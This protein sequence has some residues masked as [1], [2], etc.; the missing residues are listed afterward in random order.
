MHIEIGNVYTTV[1]EL[2][3]TELDFLLRL[4]VVQVP[5]YQHTT[6]YKNGTW[7]GYKSFFAQT[8]RR[9]LSGFLPLVVTAAHEQGI[10][11]YAT[12]TRTFVPTGDPTNFA[13]RYPSARPYQVTALQHIFTS[14]LRFE[15]I[16]AP[17]ARGIVKIPTGGGK[18]FVGG[19]AIDF[20]HKKTLFVV[21][22]KNLAHQT[23][24]ELRKLTD[25]SVGILGDGRQ[26]YGD[27]TV[28]IIQ[29]VRH[30]LKDRAF[31]KYLASIDTLVV[32]ECHHVNKGTYHQL[33]TKCP[34]FFRFGLSAT[35][36]LRMDLGNI[37]LQA[38]I[39][40]IL[41]ETERKVLEKAKYLAVPKV[42]M[43]GV[44]EPAGLH[45]DFRSAYR[46]LIV[47]NQHRNM[48]IV[49]AVKK[50]RQRGCKILILVSIL[51]HGKNLQQLLRRAKIASV[52]IRGK[53]KS[54]ER[55]LAIKTLSTSDHV[56]IATT[57]F[58]EG[59]NAPDINALILAGAGASN[60]RSIQRIGRAVRPKAD[61]N[62]CYV[63]DFVDRTNRYLLRHSATRVSV[64]EGEDFSII[65]PKSV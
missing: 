50:L 14:T 34:A 61:D 16:V 3:D 39:G 48:L 62:T 47:D 8:Y 60:I 30:K 51:D 41:V 56:L 32:D 52:Y 54:E 27:I 58:D 28:A 46:D 35:P 20:I 43:F 42:I 63:I 26:D 64:Y 7:D 15:N 49:K 25:M 19:C 4:L 1:T 65:Y 37:Y 55:E 24:K 59:M 22:R 11:I 10:K 36:G 18:T 31:L 40:S 45:L 12:D 53:T 9:F 23:A 5:G 13:K 29:T 2:A 57:V 38:D 33:L 21:E 44:R 6:A 17:W